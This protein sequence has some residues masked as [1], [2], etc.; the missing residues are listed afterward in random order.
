VLSRPF[1]AVQEGDETRWEHVV[2]ASDV[3]AFAALSGDDNQLHL[4]DA[5]ARSHGFRGRVVHGMLL[6]AWLSRVLG[7]QLPGPGVLWLSQNIRFARAIYVGD[8]VEIVVRVKHKADA[9]RTLVLE[10]VVLG[11]DGQPA[12]TGEARTMMLNTD[13]TPAWSEMTAVVT[14]GG[15]GIGAAIARALGDRG[16]RVAVNYRADAESAEA[17]AQAIRDA[18]GDAAAVQA[19][20]ATP[21]GA[22]ALVAAAE[23]RWGRVDAIVNNAT[24][25]ID[26]KPLMELEWDEIDRYWR[27]YAQSAF[28]LTQAALPGMRERG[29][30]RIVLMLTSAMWGKPPA[31]TGGYVAGKS[32]LWG[33]AKAMA[34]ELGPLGI[35]VNGV[36]PSA[37]MTDQWEGTSDSRRR[38][39]AMS[40][41]VQRLAS[42]EEVAATVMFLLGPDGAYVTGSN[43]PVAGGEVM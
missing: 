42:P 14:G 34:V 3:D 21:E 39:L 27:T 15:R 19:D 29:F 36:S 22:R 13:R 1:A 41:P 6:G 8:R 10:T 26:R 37:V 35:T 24:P 33:L 16:A 40:L 25:A 20:V 2:A 5:F 12:L 7:T 4:D 9:L 17:V 28:T 32:G 11:P 38:A 30:G 23:E 43:L 31:G 18:G